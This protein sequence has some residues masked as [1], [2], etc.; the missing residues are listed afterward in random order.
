[1][2]DA[3]AA[4]LLKL[5][6]LRSHYAVLAA[7]VLAVPLAA[8]LA[9]LVATSFDNQPGF[10]TSFDSLGTGLAAGLPLACL[11]AGVLG[12]RTITVEHASGALA[13]SLL[14]V[15]RRLVLLFAKAPPLVAVTLPVGLALAVAMHAA[16]A[17]VLGER[18]GQVLLDGRT[19]VADLADPAVPIEILAAGAL[20]PAAA[21][22]GLGV[23]AAVR[24][25]AV[26]AGV[27]VLVLVV[28]PNAAGV[29]PVPWSAR[30]GAVLLTALPAEIAGGDGAGPLPPAGALAVLATYCVVALTAGAAA[31]AARGGA[32][33]PVLAGGLAA[34]AL[35]SVAAAPAP[36]AAGSLQWRACGGELECAEL[37]VPVDWS[38]PAGPTI[39][40]A[41]ARLPHTG[42]HLRMGTVFSLPGGPGASGV[43]DL[44]DDAGVFADLRNRFDVV[45]FTPRNVTDVAAGGD[46]CLGTGP[47]IT[48]PNSPAEYAALAAG[49]RASADR[50]RA[51]DP[52]LFDHR[53]SASVARDVEAVRAALGE[54]Q[55]SFI[56]TS[57]GAVTAAAYARMFP[58]AVRAL[59]VDG[60]VEHVTDHETVART[61]LTRAEDQFARFTAW[62]A[63]ATACALHGRDVD[64]VW[65]ALVDGADRRPLAVPAEGVSYTGFDLE[66]AVQ[67]DLTQPGPGPEYPNWQRLARLV[68][69]AATGDASG[70]AQLLEQPAVGSPKVPSFVG[71]DATQCPDGRGFA[72]YAEFQRIRALGER[73]SAHFA[74]IELWHPLGCAG[75]PSPVTDPPAPLPAGLPPL[76]GAGTWTDHAETADLVSRVPGSATV[77]YDG[78][79]HG[80]Y[81]TGD[82][83]T[84][85]HV[86]RYLA[87]GRL[88]PPD[89]VCRPPT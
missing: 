8:G 63:G 83:C 15:P 20:L 10:R 61:V 32:L 28:L 16:T 60:A 4:E 82:R 7:S 54:P 42:V 74:G 87:F 58:A 59:Y 50:C 27:L 77:R 31:I 84:I 13:T 43:T 70:F 39:R 55:L 86:N 64:A 44:R 30:I 46:P 6:T 45:S 26:A 23:G 71:M 53:E 80:L 35:V 3:I 5:R 85:A 17:A 75:W 18:A 2:I 21:L 41:L 68:A 69:E 9:L 49:N 57:Y 14:G 40:L 62:C 79:G 78:P 67:A 81:L 25:T 89:T 19:L 22:I 51:A 73:L 66:V 34:A 29:L 33:R 24:S 88:P 36:S 37:D 56:A 12:A 38:E 48:V 76:L 1:M 72:D 11:A 52:A 47:W 65:T